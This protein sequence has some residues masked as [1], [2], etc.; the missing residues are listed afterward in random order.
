MG[1]ANLGQQFIQAGLIDEISIHMVP[2]LFGSGTRLFEKITDKHIHDPANGATG[3]PRTGGAARRGV[4]DT[5][6]LPLPAALRRPQRPG[7]PRCRR[8]HRA[9]GLLRR[10]AAARTLNVLTLLGLSLHLA[11]ELAVHFD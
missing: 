3:S 7:D 10:P 4:A 1:G 11:T 9:G 2:V 5:R 8:Q 6:P